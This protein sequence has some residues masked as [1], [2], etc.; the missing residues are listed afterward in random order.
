MSHKMR[1]KP[2][3]KNLKN[4]IQRLLALRTRPK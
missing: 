2:K 3:V 4:A 1:A